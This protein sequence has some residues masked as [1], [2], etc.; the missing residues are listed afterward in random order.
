MKRPMSRRKMLTIMATLAGGAGL[1]GVQRLLST[2]GSQAL[3]A[4]MTPQAYL[5][6]VSGSIPTATPTATLTP[7]ATATATRTPTATRT[8]TA[9]ATRTSTRTATP[10]RTQT[11]GVPPV[12]QGRGRAHSQCQCD[13]VG[14]S[15]GLLE[16]REPKCRERYGGPGHDGLDQ[17]RRRWRMRGGRCCRATNRGRGSP[18][19][20]ASITVGSQAAQLMR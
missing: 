20:S 8:A 2:T 5:P 9:M 4:G 7:S 17:V 14:W 6:L 3:S 16:L 12:L 15:D 1:V 13:V 19:R 18:S 10:T 11:P